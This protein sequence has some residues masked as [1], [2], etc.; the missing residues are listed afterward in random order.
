M[1]FCI[2]N[3]VRDLLL[4]KERRQ[5]LGIFNRNGTDQNR[6]AAGNLILNILHDRIKLVFLIEE[7]QIVF[8]LSDHRFVG[9]Q[10]NSVQTV[11]L[12]EFLIPNYIKEGKNGLVIAVGCT[13][14]KHRSVT[15]ANGIY[16]ELELTP[17]SVKVEHRDIG[18]DAVRKG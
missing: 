7:N 17:Y 13:G 9:W 14:G 3:T 1:E 6:T 15:L 8:I 11:D 5:F 10:Y 4:G 18:R 12:L 2:K 16:K